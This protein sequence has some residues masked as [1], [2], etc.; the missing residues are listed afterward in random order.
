[1]QLQE[2][3]RTL[4]KTVVLR[5]SSTSLI[6]FLDPPR[7]LGNLLLEFQ[8]SERELYEE[9]LAKEAA[10]VAEEEQEQ[11][12]E[13]RE[14]GARE[15][16]IARAG[17]KVESSSSSSSGGLQGTI[18]RAAAALAGEGDSEDTSSSNGAPSTS[19]D[20]ITKEA[21]LEWQQQVR[22]EEEQMYADKYSFDEQLMTENEERMKR[23]SSASTGSRSASRE[24]VVSLLREDVKNMHLK[25]SSDS[26]EEGREK[27]GSNVS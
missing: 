3:L 4:V 14:R 27:Q 7:Q 15:G 6:D 8:R 20:D 5:R 17:R 24:G 12:Q 22:L 16:G 25:D 1:M 18:F 21:D 10:A 9:M 26:D 19:Q 13:L 2:Y 23:V 11:E